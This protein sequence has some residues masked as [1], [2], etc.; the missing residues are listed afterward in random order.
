MHS[1]KEVEHPKTMHPPIEISNTQMGK[2]GKDGPLNLRRER[3]R[4]TSK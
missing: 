2:F 3:E 4:E 1:F